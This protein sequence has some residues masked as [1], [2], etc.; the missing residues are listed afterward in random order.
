MTTVQEDMKAPARRGA[1]IL[2]HKGLA[3]RR[4]PHSG[5]GGL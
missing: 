3:A 4:K 2:Q 1:A 5:D